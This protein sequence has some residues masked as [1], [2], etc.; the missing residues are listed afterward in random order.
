MKAGTSADAN[1][2]YG[3]KSSFRKI[4]LTLSQSAYQKLIA[5]AARRKITGEHNQLLSALLRE[6]V[7]GYLSRLGR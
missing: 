5:E 6:A 7:A 3:K 2:P 4:S 1:P